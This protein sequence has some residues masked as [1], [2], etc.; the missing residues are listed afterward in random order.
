MSRTARPQIEASRIK[1]SKAGTSETEAPRNEAPRNEAG[2]IET[3][4]DEMEGAEIGLVAGLRSAIEAAIASGSAE[5]LTA[6]QELASSIAAG[7]TRTGTAKAGATKSST[8]E[9]DLR[10]EIAQLA[11]S[12]SGQIAEI[13]EWLSDLTLESSGIDRDQLADIAAGDLA[14]LSAGERLDQERLSILLEDVEVAGR[15]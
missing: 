8:T 3:D 14:R 4:R 5:D 9:A 13:V 10:A 12:I 11:D 2:R 7:T 6:L 1:D 15:A